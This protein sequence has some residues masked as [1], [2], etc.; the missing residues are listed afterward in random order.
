METSDY[1][2]K[3]DLK[4]IL[5]GE[6]GVGKTN[7]INVVMGKQFEQ[8]SLSSQS[9][10][11]FEGNYNSKNGKCYVYNLWDTAG[12]E[13]YRSLNK[14]FIN[15]S[16][17]VMVVYAI[18]NRKSFEEVDYWINYVKDILGNDNDYILALVANKSDLYEEDQVVSDEEGENKASSYNIKFK[19]TSALTDAAGFKIFLHELI[20]DYIKLIGPEG[21][22]LL[23]STT[24]LKISAGKNM[25]KKKTCC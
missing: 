14:I 15:S 4:I 6:T 12:Q 24:S 1:T 22:K 20:D 10:S 25:K 8:N 19:I 11:Y 2:K 18:N 21:E 5:L 3:N 13:V 17:I 23:Y 16:K 7:L 9:G